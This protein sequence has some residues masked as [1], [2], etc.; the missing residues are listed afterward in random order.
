MATV[1]MA[2][3]LSG[4]TAATSRWP[5][6]SDDQGRAHG[7]FLGWCAPRHGSAGDPCDHCP[8]RDAH[9]R[10]CSRRRRASPSS[11]VCGSTKTAISAPASR[12]P[13]PR[14]PGI[15]SDQRE[16][17]LNEGHYKDPNDPMLESS[18]PARA[19]ARP[20]RARRQGLARQGRAHLHPSCPPPASTVRRPA[21]L[22]AHVNHE[23][24]AIDKIEGN[25]LTRP[26]RSQ[27]RQGT[28]DSQSGL[29]HLNEIL[30]P[31]R[32]VG[33]ARES[34]QW[35]RISVGRSARGNRHPRIRNGH[36]RRPPRR[37]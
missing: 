12:S 37:A 18:P 35:E 9:Q 7:P 27:L 28:G 33:R 5:C 29:R 32:R 13:S 15:M 8:G 6:T 20:H 31:L 4:A 25:P 3:E 10:D 34:G 23:T 11:W 19:V 17:G 22:L 16:R 36:R 26:A 21:G 14:S 30:H 1:L 24:G 2:V